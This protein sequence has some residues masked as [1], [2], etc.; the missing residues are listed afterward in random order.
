[1]DINFPLAHAY[2]LRSPTLTGNND[3]LNALTT[4]EQCRPSAHR[5]NFFGNW[6][7]KGDCYYA[8]CNNF[9]ACDTH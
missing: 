6:R 8:R 3:F 4:A 5:F 2:Y 7:V 1:M 9:S